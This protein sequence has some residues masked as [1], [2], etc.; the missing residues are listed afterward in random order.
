[1]NKL[2]IRKEDL[3]NNIQIIKEHA[4]T[5]LPDDNGKPVK[6]IVVVKSNAYG[7]GLKEYTQF[8]IDQGFDFFAVSTVQEA[9]EFRKLGFTQQLLMLSSTAIKEDI[10]K[11]IENNVI[12]TIGS[13]EAAEAL[14]EIVNKKLINK[15]EE[16]EKTKIDTKTK[17]YNEEQNK[18]NNEKKQEDLHKLKEYATNN[19]IK[20]HIKIDT[21]FGRYGFIYSNRDQMVEV[22]KKIQDMPNIEIQGTFTH[23]SNAYYDDKYT[24]LQFKRFIDCVEILKM[25]GINTGMLHV[26]NSSA[27]IKFPQM[28]LNAVRIGSAFSGKL[29][30]QNKL[31]LK[32]IA[33]LESKV[34]EIK[35]L[36]KKFNIGY[37]NAYKTKNVTKVAIIP[38]GYI[39]GVDV[40]VGRDMFRPVDK[41]RYI[42][43]D[44]KDVFKKQYHAV[45]INGKRCKILG[46]IGTFHITVDITGKDIK[47]GDKAIFDVNATL[48]NSNVE[49]E[50]F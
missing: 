35:E 46:R 50:Y 17:E 29:A 21:G 22:I 28:H 6:I 16:D 25:N 39:N 11:L 19:K 45:N 41:F 34:T 27:F 1:M 44:I 14:C 15:S 24:K 13:K 12:I 9:V 31:G 23:F 7:L 18:N 8:M 47:I 3:K 30:F 32:K 26:C 43:R 36:P 20:I 5:N 37:S 40:Q 42:I 4:K 38:C 48:V 2:V 10:E 49:R 33:N